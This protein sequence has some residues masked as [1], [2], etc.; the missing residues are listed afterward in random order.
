MLVQRRWRWADVV[1][2]LCK[3]FV[4]A[5]F[6]CG[7]YYLKSNIIDT[8]YSE[9]TQDVATLAQSNINLESQTVL[10]CIVSGP[11]F[12]YKLRYIVGFWLVEMAISTNPKPTIYRNLY[13]NKGDT[14]PWSSHSIY[15]V[16]RHCVRY[17]L[18]PGL[19]CIVMDTY[20]NLLSSL[21]EKGWRH[22]FSLIQDWERN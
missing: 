5:G 21:T 20:S 14:Y 8:N 9:Q 7:G 16:A 17:T 4:F 6:L 12:L 15:G 10:L 11:V 2:M 22:Q 19:S 13:D 3:Y 1:Y 18:L